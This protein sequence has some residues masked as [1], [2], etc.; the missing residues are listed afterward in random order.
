M[1]RYIVCVAQ[2]QDGIFLLA[3]MTSQYPP[4][5]A[6][7]AAAAATDLP[8][9]GSKRLRLL[10]DPGAAV[11]AATEN[12]DA[13]APLPPPPPSSMEAGTWRSMFTVDVPADLKPG[14][15]G[16]SFFH[17]PAVQRAF[18]F[19]KQQ[20]RV[21]MDA[22]RDLSATAPTQ[23]HFKIPRTIDLLNDA[24]LVF[25]LPPIWSPV[26]PPVPATGGRWA[27]FEFRWIDDL[28]AQ[29]VTEIRITAGNQ[30]L[31]LYSGDYLSTIAKRDYDAS[32]YAAFCDLTGD[33]PEVHDPA[34]AHGRANCYPSA[35]VTH[36]TDPALGTQP[37]VEGRVVRV[38]LGAW[39]TQSSQAALPVVCL[40][41]GIDLTVSVTLRPL[42]DWFRVR[43]VFDPANDFPL[44]RPDFNTLPFQLHRFL[45][46]PPQAD[47]SAPYANTTNYWNADPYLEI[48][49]SFLTAYERLEVAS[50]PQRYLMRDVK[51]Y[52]QDS[53]AGSTMLKLESVGGMVTAWTWHL[54]RSDVAARNEWANH[55][56][57][58][59][60]N[61]PPAALV[62]A[63]ASA[64]MPGIGN[65]G[66]RLNPASAGAG[67]VNTGIFL[68]G[69]ATDVNRKQILATNA[70]LIN[71][72]YL[73]TDFPASTWNRG[74]R[75]TASRGTRDDTLFVYSFALSPSAEAEQF[76]G[77]R[78][79][80]RLH[81]VQLKMSVHPPPLNTAQASQTVL[82][83]DAGNVIS[84]NVLPSGQFQYTY[85]LV[86]YEE[87]LNFVE[88]SGGYASLA[89]AT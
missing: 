53:V 75:Y 2:D 37:S 81:R 1:G 15:H 69:D 35:F 45:Q 11:A 28:G 70:V 19:G 85:N 88:F 52:R 84:V 65:L 77:G 47:V 57:W 32:R 25:T 58:P 18:G 43:D 66:P 12:F 10:D 82:C 31:A 24:Q 8:G 6:V 33:V 14:E 50:K 80:S 3:M 44:C 83:D 40:A 49:G 22:P 68:S 79:T 4:H 48:T 17:P 60:R 13:A 64:D 30:Q 41:E 73:E 55:S 71:G 51:V 34:N 20:F 23:F 54:S 78:D 46:S 26:Y 62:P 86:V 5:L 63:P 38:P 42:Q 29:V 74:L 21:D 89:V 16:A 67:G 39:F 72:E 59:Y 87:R 9:A 61:R 27:P 36:T 7:A 76:S 56:N